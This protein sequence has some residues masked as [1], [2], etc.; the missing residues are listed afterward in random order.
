[1]TLKIGGFQGCSLQDYP[2]RVASI[3]FLVNCNF[4]C[5]YCYNIDLLSDANFKASKRKLYDNN[6]VLKYL[7]RHKKMIDG[8]V[9]T[10]GEPCVNID[11]LS[12]IQKIKDL[13]L[14]VKL[15]TN[16]SNPEL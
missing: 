11:L 9:I 6:K 2:R 13:G 12:F 4:R 5:K 8:V 16:G 15:D 10:G 1:M 3:I 7:E 14:L